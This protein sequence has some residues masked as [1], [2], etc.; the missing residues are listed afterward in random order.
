[1]K[2]KE[3]LRLMKKDD[4]VCIKKRFMGIR[5]EAKYSVE[6]FRNAEDGT[7]LEE[8]VIEMYTDDET[9]CLVLG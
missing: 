3:I 7:I 5:F 8:T 9:L 1:M 2:A 6:Y 4:F